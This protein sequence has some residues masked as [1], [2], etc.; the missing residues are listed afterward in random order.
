MSRSYA[1][2][3]TKIAHKLR[4]VPPLDRQILIPD[5]RLRLK[6]GQ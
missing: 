2:G 6:L 3:G 1:A 5:F 4:D